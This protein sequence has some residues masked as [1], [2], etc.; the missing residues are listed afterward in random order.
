M[1]ASSACV[2]GISART[3]HLDLLG[4]SSFLPPCMILACS[5]AL[6]SKSK[7]SAKLQANCKSDFF[8]LRA[9]GTWLGRDR[10]RERDRVQYVSTVHIAC[11]LQERER[12]RGEGDRKEL[13]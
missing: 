4:H 5:G 7:K 6:S 1:H 8:L 13:R 10:G 12:E 3:V 11:L 9:V 2:V